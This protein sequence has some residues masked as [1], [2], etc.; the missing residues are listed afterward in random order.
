MRAEISTDT[1]GSRAALPIEIIT[2]PFV[3][4]ARLEAAGGIL[5]LA[6]TFA[7]L[8]WANS[9]WEYAYHAIWT[10]QVDIG[11]GRFFLSETRHEW[12]N[13]GLM[14]AFFFLV[15]L[16]IK[17]EVLIGELSSL[18]HA[19]FPLIAAIGG[20]IVPALIY[21][22]L[23]RDGI[24]H[25]GWGIPMATDIA[26]ALGVLAL[27]G[28][29]VPVSL[30]IFVTAL[31]IVDDIIAVL[32]IALFYTAQ[33]H[34]VSLAVALG[35]IALSFGANLLGIRKPAIYAFLGIFVWSAVLQSGVH[36]TVAGVVFAFTIP[37]RTYIDRAH[38]LK[39]GRWLLNRFEAAAPDSFEQHA[40]IH[41][42]E[43]QCELVESPLHRIEHRL[44]P[45][46]GFFVMP[47]FAFS[48][49]GVH[50]FGNVGAAAKNSVSLGV[51]LGLF[52]GKPIGISLFAWLATKAK[53]AAQPAAVSWGQI[54]GASW[55]CGIGFTMSLF[56]A[57]LAFGE[58][59]LL[60]L[61][62]IGT[63]A[64]SVAAAV[65]GSAFLLCRFGQAPRPSQV[66]AVQVAS[67]G[68]LPELK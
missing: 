2:S 53:L 19:A 62:K 24:A 40:A 55:L 60:D 14:S 41:T 10:T 18:K 7:A 51:A 43:A 6:A 11:F 47:I 5:L 12:I 16:E 32:V 66:S 3:R 48:N 65:S 50:I 15:G 49:A 54:F 17:R 13:D 63:L 35:G 31:A 4:F 42:L 57:T 22:T 23:N 68:Q 59:R 34:F 64:G 45:W 30:K 29:R 36:A 28:D 20:T 1:G 9:R 44:Q 58:G 33:I 67:T 46:V 38:F 52:L 61:S 8:V 56:I 39:Q 37:A 26:F 21:V 27:L 25:K